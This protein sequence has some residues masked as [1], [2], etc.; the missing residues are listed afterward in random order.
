MLWSWTC[1]LAL[2]YWRSHMINFTGSLQARVTFAFL[3]CV[4]LAWTTASHHCLWAVFASK[5]IIPCSEQQFTADLWYV[6]LTMHAL[7]KNSSFHFSS[8]L[9]LKWGGGEVFY[10]ERVCAPMYVTIKQRS[11][12]CLTA[13]WTKK[14]S[15]AN[16]LFPGK[17]MN[18]L[19][20]INL[21]FKKGETLPTRWVLQASAKRWR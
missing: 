11:S 16:A 1:S 13:W 12:T 19:L 2:L 3:A 17:A 10:V 7:W 21:P 5:Y 18:V 8:F 20:F 4:Y 14:T 15:K 9:M 6:I